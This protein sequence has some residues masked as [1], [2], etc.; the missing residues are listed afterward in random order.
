MYS[1]E[2]CGINDRAIA[3]NGEK[4]IRKKDNN[5]ICFAYL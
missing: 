2:A 3:P 1:S 4:L 5:I